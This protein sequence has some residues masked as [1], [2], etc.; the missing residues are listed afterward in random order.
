MHKANFSCFQPVT[1]CVVDTFTHDVRGHY[2]RKKKQKQKQK[3]K[4]ILYTKPLRHWWQVTRWGLMSFILDGNRFL[5]AHWVVTSFNLI[6]FTRP[7][8]VVEVGMG[9]GALEIGILDFYELILFFLTNFYNTGTK[10][11]LLFY[12]EIEL[13]LL[14]IL[15]FSTTQE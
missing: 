6:L 13:S 9:S 3:A 11:L 8:R 4:Y 2:F 12:M 15:R 7:Y 1:S 10:L 5:Q 14:K